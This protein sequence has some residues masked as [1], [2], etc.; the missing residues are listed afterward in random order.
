MRHIVQTVPLRAMSTPEL[1]DARRSVETTIA[2]LRAD[3]NPGELHGALSALAAI[4]EEIG[5]RGETTGAPA[6]EGVKHDD[7]KARL[8]LIPPE[9]LFALGEIL[10]YGARKYTDRNWEKGMRWG[11]VFAAATRHLWA[12]WGGRGP[13]TQSFLFGSLDDETKRSHLWHALCCVVFLVVYEERR[14]GS[15]DRHQGAPNGS[16]D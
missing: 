5:L 3:T 9:A 10:T 1:V 12:W 2:K 6:G 8:D 7:A 13:T 14:I 4:D 16:P 11:R 15:D